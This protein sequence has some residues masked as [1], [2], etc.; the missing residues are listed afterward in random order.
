MSLI[1]KYTKGWT[2]RTNKPSFDVDEEV[3]VFVTGVEDGTPVARIGDS[4]LRLVDAPDGLVDKRVLLRV[5]SFDEDA[6]VGKAE[7]LETVGESAY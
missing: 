1:S 5:T 4:K 6:H 3:S 7:Y 2:F